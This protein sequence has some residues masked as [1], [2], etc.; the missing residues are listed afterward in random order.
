MS[1]NVSVEVEFDSLVSQ[2]HEENQSVSVAKKHKTPRDKFVSKGLRGVL[3]NLDLA[4]AEE[5]YRLARTSGSKPT[6]VAR[7]LISRWVEEQTNE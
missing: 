7:E 6:K 5:F 2:A 1:K 4:L 3:V